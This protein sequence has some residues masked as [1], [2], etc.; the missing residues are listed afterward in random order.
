MHLRVFPV[1][2]ERALGRAGERA[3]ERAGRRA[4]V[5]AGER[6]LD[7]AGKLQQSGTFAPGLTCWSITTRPSQGQA[8]V[9]PLE[10]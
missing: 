5:R 9:L 6:A 10:T 7:R 8:A 3:A 4:A 1:I 2:G